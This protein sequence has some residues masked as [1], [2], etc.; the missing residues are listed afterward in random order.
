MPLFDCYDTADVVPRVVLIGAASH[1]QAA[2]LVAK[3]LDDCTCGVKA[4]RKIAVSRCE[5][6]DWSYYL[7]T[8]T[9]TR[10]A[11]SAEKE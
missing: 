6:E 2:T 10:W 11:Y 1:E 7:V 4:P 5:R 8:A 9:P 3:S